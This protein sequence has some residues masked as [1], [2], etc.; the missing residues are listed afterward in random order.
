MP[1]GA[2]SPQTF[3][4]GRVRESRHNPANYPATMARSSAGP[5]PGSL[6]EQLHNPHS[7]FANKESRG[8]NLDHAEAPTPLGRRP[9]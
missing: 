4:V 7:L 2:K 1:Q 8:R 3:A 9:G 6:S 5:Q